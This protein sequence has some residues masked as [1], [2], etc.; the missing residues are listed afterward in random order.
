M[1]DKQLANDYQQFMADKLLCGITDGQNE[2]L[3]KGEY[4]IVEM[5]DWTIDGVNCF[6][7]E[8]SHY[9]MQK[10]G[11]HLVIDL[12]NG[13]SLGGQIILKAVDPSSKQQVVKN[14][15]NYKKK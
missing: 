7:A 8:N 13:E 15:K 4:Y 2:K 11:N 10:D 9:V 5:N 12:N 1:E 6:K 14:W 3:P